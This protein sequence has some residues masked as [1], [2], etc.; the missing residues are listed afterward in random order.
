MADDPDLDDAYRL[1]TPEDHRRY[2]AGWA[3]RH[4]AEF[5]GPMGYRLPGLVAAAYADA[6]GTG[7][8]IDIGAGTGLVGAALAE[9]GIGPVDGTDISPDMLA[10]ARARGV[11]RDLA[12]AD[13]TTGAPPG[14][15]WAGLVSSGTFTL[16]HLGPAD[17]ARLLDLLSPGA[18][19]A[20]SVHA[21][22]YA[23]AG[24]AGAFAALSGRIADLRQTED[25]I[26]DAATG[27]HAGDTAMIVTFRLR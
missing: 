7:P 22:H 12:V 20:I 27:D 13:L 19:V 14:G 26:Y 1:Q 25:R 23:E 10:H 24:F 21:R 5:A 15:P 17:L 2:Y 3:A 6:G 18:R 16:G 4:D 11:Y 9:A 8:V